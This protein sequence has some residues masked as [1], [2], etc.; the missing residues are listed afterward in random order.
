M[1]IRTDAISC[2]SIIAV[3]LSAPRSLRNGGIFNLSPFGSTK[4]EMVNPNLSAMIMQSPTSY[5][6]TSTPDLSVISW[7]LIAPIYSWDT[8]QKASVGD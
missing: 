8:M 1:W 3:G 4:S 7:S 5:G 2:V 6:K